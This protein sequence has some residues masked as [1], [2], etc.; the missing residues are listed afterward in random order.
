MQSIIE[1]PILMVYNLHIWAPLCFIHKSL[2]FVSIMLSFFVQDH[3]EFL[4]KYQAQNDKNN[5]KTGFFGVR[6]ISQKNEM[7]RSKKCS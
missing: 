1:Q 6:N 7:E 2:F 5:F 3:A 4:V